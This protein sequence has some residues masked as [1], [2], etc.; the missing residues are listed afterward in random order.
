MGKPPEELRAGSRYS[1]ARLSSEGVCALLSSVSGSKD[2]MEQIE[3]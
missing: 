1:A 3:R 2:A